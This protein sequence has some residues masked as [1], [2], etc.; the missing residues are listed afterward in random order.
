MGIL[1]DLRCNGRRYGHV[2]VLLFLT[3]LLVVC[4][5][6]AKG[7]TCSTSYAESYSVSSQRSYQCSYRQQYSTKCGAFGWSRCTRYR[8]GY[9]ACYSRVYTKRYRYRVRYYCCSGWTGSG[10][11]TAV[12]SPSCQNGGRCISPDRCTCRT[13]YT[14]NRCQTPICTPRCQNGGTCSS[15]GR[16]TCTSEWRGD[17]C[18][19]PICSPSCQNDGTCSSPGRCTCTHGYTG[20]R[21]QTPVCSP[22]CQNGGT[23]TSPGRCACT[24]VY[25]GNRCQTPICTPKCQNG[26]TCSSPGECTCTNMY[27]G[28]R[29]QTP[30][31]SPKCKNGGICSSPWTC[32]CTFGYVGSVCE[33]AVEISCPG[34]ISIPTNEGVN[35]TFVNWTEPQAQGGSGLVYTNASHKSGMKFSLGTTTVTYLIHTAWERT[36]A[37][38]DFAISVVDV[39]T[40]KV[41]CPNDTNILI[42]PHNVALVTWYE[43]MPV[44]NSGYVSMTSSHHSGDVFTAGDTFVHYQATDSS[45]NVNNCSFTMRVEVVNIT[46]PNAIQIPVDKAVGNLQ[47]FWDPP[48]LTVGN[49]RVGVT[50]HDDPDEIPSFDVF[51][52]IPFTEEIRERNMY[53]TEV[54]EVVPFT[55]ERGEHVKY[56]T[57]AIQETDTITSDS[58]F[59]ESSESSISTTDYVGSM[60]LIS[61]KGIDDSILIEASTE[62][63]EFTDATPVS[64]EYETEVIT[65][66]ITSINDDIE[67]PSRLDEVTTAASNE[68]NIDTSTVTPADQKMS[69]Y[70]SSLESDSSVDFESLLLDPALHE[71]DRLEVIASHKSGDLFSV[72]VTNVTYSVFEMDSSKLVTNCTFDVHVIVFDAWFFCLICFKAAQQNECIE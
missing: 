10:C 71:D 70:W 25:T 18:Q 31:C 29:C 11:S 39:E 13:G 42:G 8:T 55:T 48:R 56:T 50:T 15:P 72:G 30:V 66:R 52:N 34:D 4:V 17:I 68:E 59:I 22:A 62:A 26:G 16:C 46:C 27:T 51:E 54:S 23:C 37:K 35:Y 21:C 36:V 58:Y 60:S 12:C 57:D 38:C 63:K 3:V 9:K 64:E 61:A 49:E 43:P 1:P 47:I 5:Q 44:D 53:S 41:T 2:M 33:Q 14:G 28:S 40:P 24:N 69:D 19:T 67:T 65:E 7:A 32:N 20:N 45:N 6:E